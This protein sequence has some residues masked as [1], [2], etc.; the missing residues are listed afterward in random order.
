L[1]EV[2]RVDA[3]PAAAGRVVVDELVPERVAD[4][5]VALEPPIM[6]SICC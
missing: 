1:S 5:G 3:A 2:E 6:F 4:E